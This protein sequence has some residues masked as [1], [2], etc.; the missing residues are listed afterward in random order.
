[1]IGF[2]I[3]K[4]CILLYFYLDLYNDGYW[5]S[6]EK[7]LYWTKDLMS[8]LILVM[9]FIGFPYLV[10]WELYVFVLLVKKPISDMGYSKGYG[11]G[12]LFIGKTHWSDKLIR[13]LYRNPSSIVFPYLMF[14]Y[15]LM[16]FVGMCIGMYRT[17]PTIDYAAFYWDLFYIAR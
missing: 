14:I 12:R 3:L 8:V 5:K 15:V 16:L 13:K 4:V 6:N 11:S 2:L 17:E 7:L 9:I 1:M 10:R